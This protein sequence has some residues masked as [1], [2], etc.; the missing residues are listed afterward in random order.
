MAKR[1]FLRSIEV[2][3]QKRWDDEKL[4]EEDAR[5]DAMGRDNTY[6]V[7][8]PYPYMNGRLHLGHAFSISKCEFA[9]SY[10][11]LQGKVCLFPFG[12]HC[13]GMPIKACADKLKREMELYGN[14]PVFPSAAVD[15]NEDKK[16]KSKVAAKTGNMTYQWDIMKSIGLTDEEV[17]K[18][19][20]ANYW[21]QYFPPYAMS[22]VKR[23]GA[24]VDWRRSMITT[25]ANPYYDRFVCWQFNTL[26]KLNKLKFGKRHTIYSE[27]DGQPCMD[28]DRA[29]G[30]GVAP[31]EYS[32]VKMRVLEPIPEKL[33]CCADKK[34]YF[35]CGTLRPETMYGQ[36]NCWIG[37]EIEYGAFLIND[38]EVFVCTE[39]AARNLA[40]QGYSPENGKVT[41]LASMKGMDLMGTA[42]KA[43][44][45]KY[46]R[47]HACPMLTVKADKGTGVVSSVPSDSPD[48]YAA[49]RDLKNKAP[50][51]EKYG[52]TDEMIM[53]YEVIPIMEIEGYG[54][55]AAVAICDEMK[56]KSQNDRDALLKAKETL[57]LKGFYEG[58][59]IVGDF[60]GNKVKDVKA[61]I[62]E[63]LIASGDVIV[64]YEPEKRVMSRSGDECVVA[65]CDQWFLDYGEE[66][67]KHATE[68]HL[69]CMELYSDEI[70]H[71]FEATLDWLNK[72][73]CSRSYG[74][75]SKLPWDK[76][77]LIE[78]LS[79]STI[80][81]AYYTIAHLLQEGV[82][83]GSK[84]NA[85]GIKPEDMTDKVF[86]FV[87]L[88]HEMP[89]CNISASNLKKLRDEF[90]Y[91]YPMNLRCSGKD[92]VPNHLTFS[93]Y[94]HC[95]I[96]PPEMCPR[97]MRANG[98]L[99]L[100]GEK[101][102]KSTGNFKTL[103]DGVNEYSADGIRYALADAGDG[104][105][106]A[107]FVEDTANAGV[108]RLYTQ[109]MWVQ[110]I[111]KAD[112]RTGDCSSFFD[113]IFASEINK[114]IVG[115]EQAYEKMMYR[116]AL[117]EGF[118]E[119]Q[120]ARDR[121][122]EMTLSYGGM[123]KDLIRRFIEVQAILIS[124]ICPH[125]AEHL[126][127]NL[128]GHPNS[129]LKA[130][131]PKVAHVDQSL[132]KASQYLSSL[133]HDL[134]VKMTP[135]KKKGPEPPKITSATI[136]VAAKYPAWQV[137]ILEVMKDSY[138]SEAKAFPD[139]KELLMKFKE[140]DCVKPYMKKV[141]PYV[142]FIKKEVSLRG[143]SAMETTVP[144][145]EKQVL[146]EAL[147][148]ITGS[149]DL[150][151]ITLKMSDE[152]DQKIQDSCMPLK[153][154]SIFQ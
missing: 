143:T 57:Y 22:D 124:P 67:W 21:L 153:P 146:E 31:Q 24:K 128:L 121:Y 1:D 37:P 84:G 148:Y 60:K 49:F 105:D 12:F 52:I 88:G 58:V 118:F 147:D 125:F 5:E 113:R 50:F 17:P 27:R 139:N 140:I 71:R 111:L 104:L 130:S 9:V 51:R 28:H 78:S 19:A 87:F 144:F 109:L 59:L 66:S 95:A 77:W 65:L 45:T 132:I 8:F 7:T 3:C 117:K 75:G 61:K 25:P 89:A 70:R 90:L 138:D 150:T 120:A 108:L 86:D 126:Y 85:M 152:G 127:T 30:E 103:F 119:L 141:M 64:Y 133:S 41:R 110:E 39:R 73:A 56:I 2:E 38:S 123:H 43:P 10:Q 29:S 40:F 98:F 63:Q 112:L 137:A 142:Q 92:L 149:L 134:R 47:I 42:L 33:K 80:Y 135:K 11:R 44:Y 35:V 100:N 82:F 91:W 69:K 18:F 93:L 114:A 94:T 4:F 136:Y 62:K 6:F 34:I 129:V 16:V 14:P 48:D 145:S 151:S 13:T 122:R 96:F 154:V 32:L 72:W 83:D 74:L 79:D 26:D 81:M 76:K 68:N 20:D 115:T 99:M 54:D 101:L 15:E 116:E 53:P 36:T 102:S 97:A 131:W 106:D 46:D 107:N 23:M 55:K